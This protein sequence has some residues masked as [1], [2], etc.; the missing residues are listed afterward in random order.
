MSRRS[1]CNGPS[2]CILLPLY[3]QY[4]VALLCAL[5]A[6]QLVVSSEVSRLI[7]SDFRTGLLAFGTVSFLGFAELGIA[8]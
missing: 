1:F 8:I 7:E 4:L 3:L 2:S 5:L 6:S